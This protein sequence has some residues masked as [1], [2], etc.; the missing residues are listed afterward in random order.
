MLTAGYGYT[1]WAPTVITP[2]DGT[3]TLDVGMTDSLPTLIVKD[4]GGGILPRDLPNVFQRF[5]R[6]ETDRD[7][8]NGAGL[9]LSIAKWI[10]EMH[11]AEIALHSERDKGTTVAV[12]FP[13]GDR[14]QESSLA[15]SRVIVP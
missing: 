2:R 10:A 9:G 13:A 15:S 1:F 5:Y 8:Q 14:L 4:T 12:A 3:I 11:G 6:G 7:G